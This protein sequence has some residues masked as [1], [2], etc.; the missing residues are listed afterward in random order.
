MVTCH[1]PVFVILLGFQELRKNLSLPVRPVGLVFHKA[2]QRKG[3]FV[4]PE[5]F[6][7]SKHRKSLWRSVQ[8]SLLGLGR[9][10][11]L[12]SQECKDVHQGNVKIN[13]RSKRH[14]ITHTHPPTAL[15]IQISAAVLPLM[16]VQAQLLFVWHYVQLL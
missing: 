3:C 8:L 1:F 10:A 6:P 12:L 2:Q 13:N 9:A 7:P 16:T 4:Y 14:T 15:W 11:M 5:S